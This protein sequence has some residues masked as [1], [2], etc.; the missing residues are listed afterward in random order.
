MENNYEAILCIVN[1]GYSDLV[2]EAAKASGARGGTVISGRGTGNPDAEQFFGIPVTPE[3]EI[4]LIIVPK[5]I[6]DT[7]LSAVNKGA[8]MDTKGM[9]IAFSLPLSDIVGL[10]VNQEQ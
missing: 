6:R 8:G 9:G 7:V 4:V 2:M 3:K 10:P 1:K 5:D